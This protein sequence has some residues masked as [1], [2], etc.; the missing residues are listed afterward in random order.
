MHP[1]AE[2]LM[3]AAGFLAFVGAVASWL[4]IGAALMR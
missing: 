2:E 4:T 1:W 3:A